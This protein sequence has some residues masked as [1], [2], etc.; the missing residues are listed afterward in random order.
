MGL[1]QSIREIWKRPKEGLGE[2]WQK[3]QIQ[4]RKEPV[5][6]KIEKPTRLDK[7]RSIGYKAKEGFVV[8]RI[9]LARGGRQRPLIKKGRRS[10][11]RRRTKIVDKSYQWIAEEKA[12]KRFT[13]LEVLNSY[14]VGKDGKNYWFEIILVDPYNPAIKADPKMNWICQ[15]QHTKRVYRG[16]TSAGRKSRGLTHKGKGAE[17]LRPSLK[18]H[19]GRG[20]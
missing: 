18:K 19:K 13:N 11:H 3:R 7:A 9:R 4:W 12:Q 5:I 15:R 8:A 16:K 2:I 14:Y 20:K 1:Y 10:K 6:V 17:K